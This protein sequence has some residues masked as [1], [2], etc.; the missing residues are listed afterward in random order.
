MD[1]LTL[2]CSESIKEFV[3]EEIASGACSSATEVVEKLVHDE[4]KRRAREKVDA[5]LDKALASG[6]PTEVTDQDWQD[7]RNEIQARAALRNGTIP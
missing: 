1:N 6:E 5:L 7:I 3:Q 4:K 2:N